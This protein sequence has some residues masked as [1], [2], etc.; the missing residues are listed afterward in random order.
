M[1]PMTLQ[2]LI[3][4]IAAAINE[5]MQRKVAA[6]ETLRRH[7][8]SSRCRS[9]PSGNC[10]PHDRPGCG[11]RHDHPDLETH[12]NGVSR[13]ANEEEGQEHRGSTE[14]RANAVHEQSWW[15][16]EILPSGGRMCLGDEFPDGTGG[17]GSRA[18]R[19][20][21]RPRAS[22]SRKVRPVKGVILGSHGAGISSIVG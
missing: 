12:G 9:P 7:P 15:H 10:Q 6:S 21:H 11:H 14:E 13:M 17:R 4:M 1:L 3:M 22:L 19:S 16:A 5:R 18:L 2:F 8:E 20:S